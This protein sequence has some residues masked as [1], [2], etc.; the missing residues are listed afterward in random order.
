MKKVILLFIGLIFGAVILA[1]DVQ[2]IGN[3]VKVY[4]D[5]ETTDNVKAV[6]FLKSGNRS[7]GLKV[8]RSGGFSY[9]NYLIERYS[10]NISIG[11]SVHA[12]TAFNDYSIGIGRGVFKEGI[13]GFNT[14][15]GHRS[16]MFTSGGF[17]TFNGFGNLAFDE[18]QNNTFSGSFCGFGRGG[19]TE[20]FDNNT[21]SGAFSFYNLS[22]GQNTGF[23]YKAGFLNEGFGNVFVGAYAGFSEKG[24]NKLYINNNSGEDP[25]I[26]G[27]FD[28]KK[29]H[30]YG[31][32]IVHGNIIYEEDVRKTT[33]YVNATYGSNAN[34]GLTP[35]NSFL[36]IQWAED[37]VP[38]GSE[39]NVSG[40][41]TWNSDNIIQELSWYSDSASI[42]RNSGGTSTFMS[43][44]GTNEREFRG[45]TF[46]R[47]STGS[48]HVSLSATGGN[49]KFYDCDFTNSVASVMV[50]GAGCL[51][52][53]EFYNCHFDPSSASHQFFLYG[54]NY[55]WQD[56][57]GLQSSAS[58]YGMYLISGVGE[59]AMTIINSEI[60]VSA[61]PF[62]YTR[63]EGNYIIE[64]CNIETLSDYLSFQQG[65]NLSY[66][67]IFQDNIFVSEHIATN[68]IIN[69]VTYEPDTALILNNK[70]LRTNI[71]DNSATISINTRDLALV[72]GNQIETF[73]ELDGT[74]VS[75]TAFS[76]EFAYVEINN[77]IIKNR[78]D[79]GKMIN[80]GTE[81]AA[82]VNYDNRLA[83]SIN[84]N[85][86]Y[87][88]YFYD[89]TKTGILHCIHLGFNDDFEINE[90]IVI[91]GGYALTLEHDG[92]ALRHT[93]HGNRL[94]NSGATAVR[95]KGFSEVDFQYNIIR[96]ELP[97]CGA[98]LISGT[99][100]LSTQYSNDCI[101]ENNIF[102]LHDDIT[103]T[104]NWLSFGTGNEP[105][106]VDKN[107]VFGVSQEPVYFIGA[108]QYVGW[109]QIQT[110]LDGDCE[111]GGI[112]ENPYND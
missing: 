51:G 24:N 1:Q 77:N 4:G 47:N 106:S 83:G 41:F 78:R 80:V 16:G 46:D 109:S 17:N 95:I 71:L 3:P 58:Y 10:L 107:K 104:Q 19:R 53:V 68:S 88:G 32:L 93:V 56:C 96:N 69:M 50:S 74:E 33:Y 22:G 34:D 60:K 90:N 94:L 12:D 11:D 87:G 8:N 20:S 54:T 37:N 57:T 59:N 91:G 15:L 64:G 108:V 42:W 72:N 89:W 67:F 29:V 62:V 63:S 25:L 100:Q 7:F 28:K 5:I 82:G 79:D 75:V 102:Y 84:G 110:A 86:L 23:G 44:T 66:N 48:Y 103:G 45:I 30:I 26:Y 43:M 35:E 27:E 98:D 9:S 111:K 61:F 99:A 70:F 55:K 38:A 21:I 18:G 13:S 36:T 112:N 92:S 14:G 85:I 105:V 2:P 65:F 40:V 73:T 39:V 31:D 101:I 49:I 52:N 6:E 97:Y 76:G 81:N